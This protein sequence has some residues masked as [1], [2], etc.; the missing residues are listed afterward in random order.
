MKGNYGTPLV[1]PQFPF[2]EISDIVTKNP[3]SAVEVARSLLS[4][5]TLEKL[6]ALRPHITFADVA[7]SELLAEIFDHKF[8]ALCK[9]SLPT[10]S[11]KA[12]KP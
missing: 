8:S 4:A 2:D 7:T 10:S 12:K 5:D 3:T 6:E 9:K 1:L 11:R